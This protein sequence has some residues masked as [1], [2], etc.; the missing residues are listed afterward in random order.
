VLDVIDRD[1]HMVHDRG[2]RARAV[3][4]VEGNL[5]LDAKVAGVEFCR[6]PGRAP[7]VR[8]TAIAEVIFGSDPV[9]TGRLVVAYGTLL[10]TM[11]HWSVVVLRRSISTKMPRIVASAGMAKP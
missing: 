10:S 9:R 5:E 6:R 11:V 8:R 4:V 1:P 3:V 7:Q 2:P